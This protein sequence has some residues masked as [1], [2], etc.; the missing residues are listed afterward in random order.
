MMSGYRPGQIC[1]ATSVYRILDR[2][3]RE[4]EYLRR[5]LC[6]DPFPPAPGPGCRFIRAVWPDTSSV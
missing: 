1:P 5:V 3:G 4:T 2:L 6:G